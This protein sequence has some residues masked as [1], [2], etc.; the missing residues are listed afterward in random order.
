MQLHGPMKLAWL[1]DI[2][3]N[4]LGPTELSNFCQGLREKVCDALL[5]TGDIAEAPTIEHYLLRLKSQIHSP[6]YFVLGN[7]DFYH[8]SIVEVARRMQ[9]HEGWLTKGDIVPLCS[10]SALIGHDGWADGRLGDYAASPVMLRDYIC[11]QELTGLSKKRRLAVLNNLGD[12]AAAEL[13]P[14]LEKTLQQYHYVYCATH[15]PPF[16][17]ACWHEG[18]ISDDNYLPHFASKVMGDMLYEVMKR[19]PDKKLTVLCG[20]THSSGYTK[21]LPNLDV[22]T[23][24]AVYGEPKI[25]EILQLGK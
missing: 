17:E 23:G 24:A 15:V 7:H 5:I 21:I 1:T 9:H 10:T 20:H 12:K 11:I 4:F 3:L 14:T 6:I 19:H 18:K 16:K 2:H 8:G 25:Q 22:K 13:K